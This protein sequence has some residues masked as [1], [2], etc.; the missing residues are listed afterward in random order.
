MELDFY[1]MFGQIWFL[2]S[3]ENEISNLFQN[4]KII[5]I[6]SLI[7]KLYSL[8][9]QNFNAN[10]IMN[11]IIIGSKSKLNNENSSILWH[12]YLGHISKQPMEG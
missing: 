8:N 4:S 3:F 9:V 10:L 12:K 2:Y 7:D 5:G 6:G 1:F 11:A